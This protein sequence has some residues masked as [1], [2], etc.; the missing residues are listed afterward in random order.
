MLME[1]NMVENDLLEERIKLRKAKFNLHAEK[2][3][4]LYRQI[5]FQKQGIINQET[6]V[7]YLDR[8]IQNIGLSKQF[9]KQDSKM[10]NTIV[11][12]EFENEDFEEQNSILSSDLSDDDLTIYELYSFFGK[13]VIE[14]HRE[15]S[16][17]DSNHDI[18]A[19]LDFFAILLVA[20]ILA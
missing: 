14:K 18:V 11:E 15:I 19:T 13:R 16:R 6:N 3:Q 5:V 1:I 17:N 2:I 20:I 9:K 4:M 10:S 7:L 8:K 12:L